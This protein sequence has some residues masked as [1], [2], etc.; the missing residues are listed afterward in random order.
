MPLPGFEELIRQ[1]DANAA[2]L[3]IAAVGSADATVLRAL[4]IASD[5][6][7]IV[8]IAVGA[9]Q[10]IRQ[11]AE[12]EAIPL[13][14]F[15]LLDAD[16]ASMASLAVAEVRAGRASLLMKGQVSTPTLMAA[17]LD[18]EHGLRTG[19]TV[20][21]VVLMEIPR[22]GRSFLLADTGVTIA[23]RTRTKVDILGQA[24]EVARQLGCSPARV[25]MLAA[26]ESLNTQMPE[27]IEA[28]EL[29]ARGEAGEF[30]DC[31]I[32]GPLSFD[33]AYAA[34]AA[35]RKR[36]GGSVVGAADVLIFPSLLA[37]NLTVKAIMYTAD[38]RFGGVLR[39]VTHPVV[40]MSRADT[41][42]TRLRSIALAL[43]LADGPGR[44]A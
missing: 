10:A 25:A 16:T 20:C 11:T 34:D 24:V 8:P 40:F 6:G 29:Q 15:R 18:P 33:L 39:G 3:P 27:T 41:V 7:W 5:R 32:Q 43:G 23:P 36:I 21:Q 12:Q 2:R 30:P 35:D 13:D 14:G 38:C 28:A 9:E 31:L 44:S 26:S 1:A 17:V 4:R 22:D 37:A 42:E 19:R